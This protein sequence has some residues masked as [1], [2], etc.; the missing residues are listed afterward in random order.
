MYSE[1]FIFVQ[2]YFGLYRRSPAIKIVDLPRGSTAGPQ[3]PPHSYN[4]RQQHQQQ[5]QP[6]FLATVEIPNVSE[7]A[8]PMEATGSSKKDARHALV[9]AVKEKIENEGLWDAFQSSKGKGKIKSRAGGDSQDGGSAGKKMARKD[10]QGGR[11]NNSATGANGAPVGGFKKGADPRAPEYIPDSWDEDVASVPVPVVPKDQKKGK[12]GNGWNAQQQQETQPMD[13]W[14]DTPQSQSQSQPQQQAF[15]PQSS[16]GQQQYGHNQNRNS[17]G[18]SYQIGTGP[19]SNFFG[20]QQQDP[21][22]QNNARFNRPMRDRDGFRGR[23]TDGFGGGFDS[24]RSPHHHNMPPPAPH[25]STRLPSSIEDNIR[26]YVN[27]YCSRFKLAIPQPAPHQQRNVGYT[28][29]RARK[30]KQIMGDWECRLEVPRHVTLDGTEQGPIIGIGY[31]K[32]KKDCVPRAWEDLCSRLLVLSPQVLVD[33][34]I[35][36]A[37][38]FKK[39]LQ[40]MLAVPVRVE[41]SEAAV[42]RLEAVLSE[43]REK[44]AFMIPKDGMDG[45]E[46]GNLPLLLGSGDSNGGPRFPRPARFLS[47]RDLVVPSALNQ[48]KDLPMYSY[49]SAIIAAVENNPVVILSAETGAGKKEI[50]T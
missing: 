15:S 27:F 14:D 34:F 47:P 10:T 18:S 28:S 22:N 48:S 36:Y 19:G 33:Q 6:M 7:E 46:H 50:N 40:E 32:S 39:R 9:K 5:Q 13:W 20:Q 2:R 30:P 49:Y 24:N 37:T 21:R 8:I 42:A 44:R 12:Q 41:V 4:S 11:N 43:M 35:S 31:G 1:D 16:R 26:K 17:M 45:R 23:G 25:S 3:A 38:P 29:H